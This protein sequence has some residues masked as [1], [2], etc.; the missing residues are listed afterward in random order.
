LNYPY[1]D[2]R[3]SQKQQLPGEEKDSRVAALYGRGDANLLFLFDCHNFIIPTL[4]ADCRNQ[5]SSQTALKLSCDLFCH[6][7][8]RA[9]SATDLFTSFGRWGLA[10]ITHITSYLP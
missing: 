8:E 9:E 4:L 7:I 3:C 5:I 1:V 2:Y 10:C 6:L